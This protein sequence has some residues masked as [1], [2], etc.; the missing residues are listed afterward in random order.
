MEPLVPQR[1]KVCGV[2]V[3]GRC[4]LKSW[5]QKIAETGNRGSVVSNGGGTTTPGTVSQVRSRIFFLS[6]PEGAGT[7][8]FRNFCRYCL[9]IGS[10]AYSRTRNELAL[11]LSWVETG[12]DIRFCQNGPGKRRESLN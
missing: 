10:A 5:P 6:S 12:M 7:T 2:G 9:I 1:V 8:T 3:L 4:S 11:S